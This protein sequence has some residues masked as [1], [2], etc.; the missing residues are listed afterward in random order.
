MGKQAHFH[1]PSRELLVLEGAS[2]QD[3]YWAALNL[4]VVPWWSVAAKFFKAYAINCLATHGWQCNLAHFVS[5]TLF[6]P[7]QGAE[8]GHLANFSTKQPEVD[9]WFSPA[10]AKCEALGLAGSGL[11]D[12]RFLG[13][14]AM[15]FK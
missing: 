8:I 6:F 14:A 2:L 7:I 10:L 13:L 11:A 3:G 1:S 5:G 12:Q 15:N 4:Y 9:T